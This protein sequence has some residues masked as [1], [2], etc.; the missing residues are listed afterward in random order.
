MDFGLGHSGL[1]AFVQDGHSI[2]KQYLLGGM[3]LLG[4]FVPAVPPVKGSEGCKLRAGSPWWPH[5]V[6]NL[7]DAAP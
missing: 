4:V 5:R 3:I 2:P 6:E 7:P 1:R